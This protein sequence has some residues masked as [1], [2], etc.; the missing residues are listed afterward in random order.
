[1]LSI[2]LVGLEDGFG[3]ANAL[4]YSTMKSRFAAGLK[5]L[6]WTFDENAPV[7]FHMRPPWTMNPVEGK[8]NILLTMWENTEFP[9]QITEVIQKAD[10]I[11]VPSRFCRD[12]FA[13][14][15]SGP[16]E[17]VP[18]GCDVETYTYVKRQASV[19][20]T[21]LWVGAPNLRKGWNML[22]ELWMETFAKIPQC[23][24]YLKT[25][26]DERNE[27]LL[28]EGNVIFDSRFITKK[29]L[30][31][32]YHKAHAFVLPHYGEGW[33]LTLA[34]AMATGLPSIATKV[35]GVLDFTD[36]ESVYY[37]DWKPAHMGYVF[38][39][40]GEQIVADVWGP[41]KQEVASAME[42]IIKN[43]DEALKVGKKAS[44]KI[45]RLFTWERTSKQL[46]D[47]LIKH[48]VATE[49]AE[50]PGGMGNGYQE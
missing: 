28:R 23:Q 13:K 9:E 3:L 24:L 25:T 35:T 26:T 48:L 17:I 7:A 5:A 30:V 14:Y 8:K 33:G 47:V 21:F 29:E 32:L 4:G 19:P 31:G 11:I 37:V 43:Y 12:V 42:R 2:D 16:I 39:P 22:Y 50:I 27:E 6:G 1:M 46:S 36:S 18:L 20:F 49:A 45:N 41:D 44:R 34:E 40:T 38:P 15:Y 10:A